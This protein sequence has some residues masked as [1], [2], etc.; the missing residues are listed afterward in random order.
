MPATAKKQIESKFINGIDVNVL[1]GAI[2]E[3]SRDD[4]KGL[5]RWG[6]TTNWKGGARTETK[7]NGYE[8]GGKYVKKNFTIHTDEPYELAG[9]N[10]N[11]NPQEVL[12]AAFNACMTVGYAALCALEGI[13]LEELRIET[14]GDLD[15]RGFFG[16][17][18]KVKPGY[19]EISY[20]V[21]IKGNGTPEQFQKI[22]ETV[23]ATSPNRFNIANPIKLN[24]HLVVE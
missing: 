24:T 15:L 9:T 21:H 11:A 13:E 3:V 19:E 23:C 5:T 2:Q 6:V 22:H 8:I 7:V 14:K 16:L 20:T 10:V 1:S 17:D 12:M 4:S 18:P